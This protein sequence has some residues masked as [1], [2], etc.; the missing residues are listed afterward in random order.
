MSLIKISVKLK[1][2]HFIKLLIALRL[3][4]NY[5]HQNIIISEVSEGDI[6][7]LGEEER[8]IWG[9]LGALRG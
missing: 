3:N 8:T 5:S 6:F 7:S 2:D 9:P 4:Y 1:K